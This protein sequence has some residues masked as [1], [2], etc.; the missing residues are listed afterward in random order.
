[1]IHGE[2]HNSRLKSRCKII[3]RDIVYYVDRQLSFFLSSSNETI[4]IKE[5]LEGKNL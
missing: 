5:I 1:M 4:N 3:K 2:A